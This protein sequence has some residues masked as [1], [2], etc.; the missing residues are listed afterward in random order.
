MT[1]P[2]ERERATNRV[3]EILARWQDK[4]LTDRQALNALCRNL[5]HYPSRFDAGRY[6]EMEEGQ[7]K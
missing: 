5:H 1:L 7:Q 4:E 6:R 2:N 3:P